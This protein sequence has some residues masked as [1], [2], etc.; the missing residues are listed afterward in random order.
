MNTLAF[1]VSINGATAVSLASLG[2]ESLSMETRA[3][4][5]TAQSDDALNFVF[6]LGVSAARPFAFMDEIELFDSAS[7]R[8]FIGYARTAIPDGSADSQRQKQQVWSPSIWLS[9]TFKDYRNKYN[10]TGYNQERSCQVMINRAASVTGGGIPELSQ[11]TVKAQVEKILDYAILTGKGGAAAPFTY[12]TT[13]LPE[14][15]VNQDTA[16]SITCEA[17][18]E[19]AL[20]QC[21]GVSKYWDMTGTGDPVLRF[22]TMTAVDL[23]TGDLIQPPTLEGS[24]TPINHEVTF[25]DGSEVLTA[26][27]VPHEE[28]MIG[29]F[30]IEF[31]TTDEDYTVRDSFDGGVADLPRPS[32][33]MIRRTASSTVANSSP[34]TT[35]IAI[36]LKGTVWNGASWG[37]IES[38]TDDQQDALA[39]MLHSGY[40]TR[41]WS[42]NLTS[43]K[44]DGATEADFFWERRPGDTMTLAGMGPGPDTAYAVIQSISRVLAGPGAGTV[45]TQTGPPTMRGLAVLGPR[46]HQ[47]PPP[48]NTGGG[49][50]GGIGW[51]FEPPDAIDGDGDHPYS[52]DGSVQIYSTPSVSGTYGIGLPTQAGSAVISLGNGSVQVNDQ[53]IV[54]GT[55]SPG[56]VVNQS[57]IDAGGHTW[58]VTNGM[59]TNY[60]P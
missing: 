6:A 2:V 59:L 11:I 4:G 26:A 10:A 7:D 41:W 52:Y 5:A 17:A 55:T 28:T 22:V 56:G 12:D 29:T 36:H 39:R 25:G 47:S 18:L 58:Q 33:L 21:P 9:S 16:E 54:I 1:T 44:V 46:K 30:E 57:F 45:S 3:L 43:R 14:I 19:R 34:L 23:D 31:F 35:C 13:G 20:A 42:F 60:T 15:Y 24:G 51:D 53:G 37:N 40:A 27:P 38:L 50:T 49:T 32:R 48:A 8:R